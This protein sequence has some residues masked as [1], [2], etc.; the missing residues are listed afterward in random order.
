MQEFSV[1]MRL[2]NLQSGAPNGTLTLGSLRP[3]VPIGSDPESVVPA[4]QPVQDE[5][6]N[7]SLLDS[8][9]HSVDVSS[10]PRLDPGRERIYGVPSW[11]HWDDLIH[12]G[13]FMKPHNSILARSWRPFQS[14]KQWQFSKRKE[15]PKQVQQTAP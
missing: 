14:R 9:L 5:R 4:G 11:I 13:A 8:E 15:T 7:F 3:L 6:R 2:Y 12:R 10:T 1:V